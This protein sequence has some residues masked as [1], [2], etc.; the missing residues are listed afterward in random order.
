MDSVR[1]NSAIH[2]LKSR[3]E[4]RY[5]KVSGDSA[6]VGISE[7]LRI[8]PQFG[9]ISEPVSDTNKSQVVSYEEKETKGQGSFN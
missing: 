3:T 2:L 1:H 5:I 4:L 8:A 9:G 6:R 7:I